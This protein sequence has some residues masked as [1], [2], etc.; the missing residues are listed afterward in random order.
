[1]KDNLNPHTLCLNCMHI[2]EQG[3]LC[4]QCGYDER[5]YKLHPLYLKAKTVLKEQY[6]I[7]KILG[8]GGFGVTYLGFDLWLQK[9]VAIKEYLPAALATR[10]FVTSTIVPLKKQ[11]VA[12][13]QGLE[14]FI[15]EA[16]H[17]AKF[18]HPNIVRVINFFEENQTGYMVMEY[19]EGDSPLD[20]LNRAGG[21]LS[22]TQMLAIIFPLLDALTEIHAQ[23]IYH[24]DISVQNIRILKTGEPVLIDFGAARH[25]VGECS[26][27][28]DLVLKHGYS[29]LEQYSG[30][31]K[32]GAWTDIYACGALMYLLMTGQLPPAATDRYGEDGLIPPAQMEE[33]DISSITNDVIVR[34]LAV[35]WEERFHCVPD[36]KLA[37]QGK[38]PV[39]FNSIVLPSLII[40]A[41]KRYNYKIAVVLIILS[42]LL[43]FPW[44]YDRISSHS[45]TEPD[46]SQLLTQANLQWNAEKLLTPPGDNAYET[47]QRILQIDANNNEAIQGV[48][49]IAYH[50]QHLAQT[51]QQQNQLTESLAFIKQAL[52]I[53]PNALNL[54]T[55]ERK[56]SEEI[57]QQEKLMQQATKANK[58]KELLE[59]A[60]QYLGSSQ[61]KL[62]YDTYQEILN[63]DSTQLQAKEGLQK[64]PDSYEKLARAQKDQKD[65]ETALS[66]VQQGLN[67]FPNH[68]NLQALQ[69]E[70]T[71]QLGQQR[72]IAES[73]QKVKALLAANPLTEAEND[74]AL[75]MCRH[76][77]KLSPNHPQA[78]ENI[79]QIADNYEKLARNESDTQKKLILVQKGLS[80]IP[81]H[82]GLLALN[83]ILSQP[84]VIPNPPAKEVVEKIVEKIVERPVEKVVESTD[85][86]QNLLNIAKKQLDEQKLDAAYQ[87]YRNIVTL[88]P[89]NTEAREGLLQLA[90]KYYQVA[91]SKQQQGD[92]PESSSLVE[93]GL[94][95]S[96]NHK[97]LL[98]LQVE[99]RQQTERAEREK[100]KSA[101]PAPSIILTPSF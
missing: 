46:F 92:T 30:K 97:G 61:L 57:V 91:K 63:L 67:L 89:E 2:K 101:K 52:Q 4:P 56:V 76:L 5:K 18:D 74:N 87:T 78:V 25:V 1:M 99:I 53:T 37:L 15:N 20:I 39:N 58:I 79:G 84:I 66:L 75:D 22:E 94:Q 45:P 8:Q 90:E 48:Q 50:F 82:N 47:Y 96:P 100:N 51:A 93:K 73:L 36:V 27:S 54:L 59:K 88:A 41:P 68:L 33:I 34:A 7:G 86:I 35:R 72:T 43:L 13:A 23:S 42:L 6:V 80:I 24:R 11:E 64:I 98:A 28:L 95:A 29:P 26:H 32:I 14:L 81:R 38:Q 21:K 10:D 55:L 71:Q 83:K 70:I 12:F 85:T 69:K 62:A 19:L 77:L 3:A 31:G 16:R 40:T 44:I 60:Q 49:R 65:S 9:K 17:L